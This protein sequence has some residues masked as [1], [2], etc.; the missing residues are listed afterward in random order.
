[1]PKILIV[2]D[3]PLGLMLVSGVVMATQMPGLEVLQ[4][5]C[6]MDALAMLDRHEVDLI[7]TDLHMNDVSGLQL[8]QRLR[9]T[10]FNCP[11]IV[12]TMEETPELL[13]RVLDAGATMVMTKRSRPAEIQQALSLIGKKGPGAT[14]A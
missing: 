11:I 14:P 13:K 5:R 3:N 9:K 6:A 7:F 8:V 10:G 4:A 1:V 2:D 12:V